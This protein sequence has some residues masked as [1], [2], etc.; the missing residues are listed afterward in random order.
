MVRTG[1]KEHPPFARVEWDEALERIASAACARVQSE[2][3]GEAILPFCYGG[4]NGTAHAGHVC[5]ATVLPPAR[6]VAAGAHRVRRAD[7]RRQPGALRQDA[8]DHVR[9]LPARAAHRAVG[10]EPGGRP[11]FTRF[12]T[13]AK[14]QKQW[15]HARRHR[16]AHDA[17]S[18][19]QADLHL[20][21]GPAL[22][23]RS[24][25]RFIGSCSRKGSRTR[26]FSPRNADGAE[27]LRERAAEWTFERAADV[28][29]VDAGSLRR[30]RRSWYADALPAL[31]RCGWGLERNRNGGNAALAV[32]A[33]PAVGGKFGVRGGGYAMSNPTS[34]GIARS[35]VTATE[36]RDARRQHESA[37]TRAHRARRPAGRRCC[38]ST[39]A[40]L[41]S[42]CP[43][44]SGC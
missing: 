41:R 25:S 43:I 15:R 30:A 26:R 31:I 22:M 6:C 11:A 14:P 1:S 29:G 32:L 19:R 27:R 35:W 23:W 16:S 18:P 40:T 33:L 13:C 10:H 21:V 39:T 12:R 8:V 4:S 36:P 9:G 42:P 28:A 37:R 34:W 2:W 38:S 3:G 7:G 44:S 24:R 20:A 17:R 5:D